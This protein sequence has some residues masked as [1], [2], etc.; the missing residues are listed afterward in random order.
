VDP[1]TA[2]TVIATLPVRSTALEPNAST[3]ASATSVRHFVEGSRPSADVVPS[4]LYYRYLDSYRTKKT[5]GSCVWDTDLNKIVNWPDQQLTNGRAKNTA[6]G[7]RYK[8]FVRALKRAENAL[9]DAGTIDDLP[10]YFMECLVWNVAN[11][12]LRSGTLA[13]GFGATLSELYSGLASGDAGEWAEPNE[14]KWLFKGN[15]KWTT[16]DGKRLVEAT[17]NFLDY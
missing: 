16:D 12:T 3:S 5:E 2:A 8:Y 7:G 14:M 11:A 9:V 6:T 4:F 15:K 10:S 13:T 17:W 1:S